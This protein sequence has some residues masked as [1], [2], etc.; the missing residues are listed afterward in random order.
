M[1]RLVIKNYNAIPVAEK[2]SVLMK[3]K[4]KTQKP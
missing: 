1:I 3:S 4:I 2:I